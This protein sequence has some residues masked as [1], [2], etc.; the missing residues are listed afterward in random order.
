MKRLLILTAAVFVGCSDS[1]PETTVSPPKNIIPSSALLSF[2][3]PPMWA[4][5]YGGKDSVRVA[6]CFRNDTLFV[7][8]SDSTVSIVTRRRG[9]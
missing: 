6:A 1:A 7:E 9:R 3:P 2:N 5:W 8:I 4:E